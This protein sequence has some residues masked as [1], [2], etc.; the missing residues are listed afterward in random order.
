MARGGWDGGGGS[1]E[2]GAGA[3]L[4]WADPARF[5]RSGGAGRG[6]FGRLVGDTEVGAGIVDGRVGQVEP[7][8]AQ[9]VDAALAEGTATHAV[10][11]TSRHALTAEMTG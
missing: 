10:G 8:G 7:V 5:P 3:D 11:D 1:G 2:L 4:E 6:G 9:E